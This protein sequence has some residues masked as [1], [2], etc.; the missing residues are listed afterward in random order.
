M[1]LIECLKLFKVNH[2]N[3]DFLYYRIASLT[4]TLTAGAPP[5]AIAE[6]VSFMIETS[7]FSMEAARG[8]LL[9]H[10][11][12]RNFHQNWDLAEHSATMRPPSMFYCEI[13]LSSKLMPITPTTPKSASGNDIINLNIAYQ[14]LG[15]R[16]I[17]IDLSMND[18]ENSSTDSIEKILHQKTKEGTAEPRRLE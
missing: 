16:P 3:A 10:E 18:K 2:L 1:H 15:D 9:A 4:N 14:T 6:C 11:L 7:R 5:H 8:Y 12:H 13:P 17:N